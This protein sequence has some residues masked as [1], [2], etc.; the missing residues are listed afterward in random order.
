MI[1]RIF[2]EQQQ[3]RRYEEAAL[4]DRTRRSQEHESLVSQS[5][6]GDLQL[7]SHGVDMDFDLDDSKQIPLSEEHAQR[8]S[9]S[10]QSLVSS[11]EFRTDESGGG[12]DLDQINE[13]LED[14]DNDN[15]SSS[16]SRSV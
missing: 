11:R 16:M 2:N 5:K 12:N 7:N 9:T 10:T 4:A 3:A 15:V 14:S 1:R 6:D 8:T 13:D